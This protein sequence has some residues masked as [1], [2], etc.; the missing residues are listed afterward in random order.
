MSNFIRDNILINQYLD[1]PN[2]DKE[3]YNILLFYK[4]YINNNTYENI[5]AQLQHIINKYYFD[6]KSNSLVHIKDIKIYKEK[7]IFT[8]EIL[9]ND[10]I[11]YGHQTLKTLNNKILF[12][13]R[14]K[15]NNNK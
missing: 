8:C 10:K 9:H 2:T 3:L 14:I 15:T 6:E 13:L 7:L 11:F 4:E 1:N 5:A 12:D